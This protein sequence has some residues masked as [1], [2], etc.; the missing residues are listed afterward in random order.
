MFN[1]PHKW[2][3]LAQSQ[4]C[5]LNQCKQFDEP[6]FTLL[7]KTAQACLSKFWKSSDRPSAQAADQLG[8]AGWPAHTQ[9]DHLY[10]QF[11]L[12]DWP[13]H[14]QLD[15]LDHADWPAHIQLDHLYDQFDLADWP[16]HTQLDQL[17]TSSAL[18]VDQLIPS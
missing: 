10:D 5:D 13:A 8:H 17:M 2:T 1:P 12:A 6:H 16:A 11:D 15:Q 4:L 14:T 9:L 3:S 18:L 7:E